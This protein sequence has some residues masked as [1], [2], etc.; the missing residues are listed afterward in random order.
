[1]FRAMEVEVRHAV[2]CNTICENGRESLVGSRAPHTSE[3]KQ[4][5]A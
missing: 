1:M 5:L 4:S 3:A 2:I